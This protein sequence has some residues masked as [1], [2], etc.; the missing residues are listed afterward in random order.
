MS[1]RFIGGLSPSGLLKTG[2]H[3]LMTNS[4]MRDPM[5]I[6]WTEDLGSGVQMPKSIAF[7][8][9]VSEAHQAS[10]DI[11]AYPVESGFS[12]SDHSIRRNRVL[13]VHGTIMN[14][15]LEQKMLN[16]ALKIGSALIGSKLGGLIATGYNTFNSLA[17]MLGTTEASPMVGGFNVIQSL[18]NKGTPVTA[19]TLLG[20]YSPC[21]IKSMQVVQDSESASYLNV[22]LVIEE[23]IMVKASG[24]TSLDAPAELDSVTEG[25]KPKTGLDK[26]LDKGKGLVDQAKDELGQ[27]TQGLSSAGTAIAGAAADLGQKFNVVS[28]GIA[29]P[30]VDGT[31]KYIPDFI[32]TAPKGVDE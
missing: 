18:V 22:K 8:C 2:A 14:A 24:E 31:N 26:L 7:D 15:V 17:G 32:G 1:E 27:A 30:I 3:L 6:T 29:A 20:V 21:I 19:V 4:V 12:V 28:Q 5:V 10:C 11:T 16:G 9:V 25:D 13:N 23:V